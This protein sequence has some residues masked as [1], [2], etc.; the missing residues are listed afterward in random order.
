MNLEKAKLNPNSVNDRKTTMQKAEGHPER[1]APRSGGGKVVN[2]REI[3]T[4]MGYIGKRIK[5]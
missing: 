2:P 3:P 5:K 1:S 4:T